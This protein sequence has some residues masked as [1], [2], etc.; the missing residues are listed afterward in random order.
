MIILVG[1]EKGG[2][3]KTTFAVNF[4]VMRQ[5][6]RG[7]VILVDAEPTQPNASNW[8][9]LRDSNEVT[10]RIP[11]VQK[12]GKNL[13]S[14]IMA[15]KK[16]YE[17]IVIDTGGQDT[18]ELRA[19]LLVADVAISPLR[20]SQFDLWTIAK[21]D[22]LVGEVKQINEGLKFLVFFNQA[23]TNP[24]VTEVEDA[25]KYVQEAGFEHIQLADSIICER[26]AFRK[27]AN[28]GNSVTELGIDKKAESEMNSLYQE[29][30]R[31][32]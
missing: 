1:G 26:I 4:A 3:G 7:D 17:D 2:T 29:A 30:I 21:L 22:R 23:S 5:I 19:G 18:V 20:P 27:M 8:C 25:R 13:R 32:G 9:V 10:P 31:H 14:D 12:L 24:Q 28:S 11:S 16:K 6:E 15:L